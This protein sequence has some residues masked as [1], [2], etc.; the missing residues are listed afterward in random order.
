M[1][2]NCTN[3]GQFRSNTVCEEN[4]RQIDQQRRCYCTP[5]STSLRSTWRTPACLVPYRAE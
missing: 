2:P 3:M 4:C 5:F 1:I